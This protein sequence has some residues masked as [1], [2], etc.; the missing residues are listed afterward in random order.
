MK[1]AVIIGGS[2][3]I[4]KAISVQL[5]KDWIAKLG[6]K[7]IVGN[8]N[9]IGRIEKPQDVANLV[10]FLAS[11]KASYINGENIGINVGSNLG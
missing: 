10:G 5:F 4:G 6:G 9:P 1:Y 2:R 3:G 11:E 8:S 7:E